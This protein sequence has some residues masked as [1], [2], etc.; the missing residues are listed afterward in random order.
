MQAVGLGSM[1]QLLAA[2]AGLG[3]GCYYSQYRME[4]S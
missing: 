4:D 2:A 1:G 3:Y